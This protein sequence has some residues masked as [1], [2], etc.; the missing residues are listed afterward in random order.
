MLT[1]QCIEQIISIAKQISPK[2]G[3]HNPSLTDLEREYLGS[4][5]DTNEVS[6]VGAMVLQ[7]EKKLREYTGSK[8]AIPVVNGTAA[9]SLAL[10]AVG[11]KSGDLVA[12]QPLTFIGT[13]NAIAAIGAVPVFVDVDKDTGCMSALALDQLLDS[14]RVAAIVPVHV[15]GIPGRVDWLSQIAFDHGVPM[16][17]DA[18]EALGSF[19]KAV[20][21]G[22]YGK[23]GILSFNGNKTITTGGGG[24]VLTDDPEVADLIYKL[25]TQ[26]KKAHKW[27]YEHD[28]P[29]FNLR[30]PNINAALGCA[31]MARLDNILEDKAETFHD[32][33]RVFDECGCNYLDATGTDRWNHWLNTLLVED[34]EERTHLLEALNARGVM[35]R[36][37][38]KLLNEVGPYREC[39]GHDTPNARWLYERAIALP[40]GVKEGA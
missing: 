9:L 29:A 32:Y 14:T 38:W 40:S 15:Q 25:S 35:A 31:Q 19:H 27:E 6:S 37:L 7:F 17:E 24:A 5:I 2:G 12:T 16:V 39:Q 28:I 11:V 13:C 23:A 4:C 18:A 21:C 30:M 10:K 34:P 26:A 33:K 8:F 36:P 3:L 20:H 22:R 1:I